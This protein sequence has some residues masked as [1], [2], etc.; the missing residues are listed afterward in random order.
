MLGACHS[1]VLAPAGDVAAQ[2]G[3]L[4]IVAT[5]LMLLVVA[6]VMALTVLFAWR[7]RASGKGRYEPQW[8]H[9]TQLELI[10]WAAP[11][12]IIICLG[13]LTWTST[14][15]LDPFRPLTR[16]E[17]G[18]PLLNKDRQLT[19]QVIALD[20]KWLFIY[21]QLRIATV[22]ELV[23]PLDTP[24]DLSI[25]AASVMNSF[26]APALA[27][28]VYAMPGMQTQLHAVLNTAGDYEGFS[29]NYSGAGFSGMRFRLRGLPAPAFERWLAEVRAAGMQLDRAAYLRLAR[30]SENEPLHRYAAVEPALYGAVLRMCVAPGTP[31]TGMPGLADTVPADRP[32]RTAALTGAGLPP[33]SSLPNSLTSAS[34]ASRRFNP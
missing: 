34:V 26:Y 8:S 13:A 5:A 18:R 32:T 22:N 29:A 2:Q 23:V 11:L 16:I 17:R 25:T 1:V 3:H 21:P 19:V 12:L 6:P 4:V 30:P 7:Y 9:A 24:L 14:H 10:I 20:W 33:P 15:Q 27:G 28:Q 31:C